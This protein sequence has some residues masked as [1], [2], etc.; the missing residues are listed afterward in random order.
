MYDVSNGKQNIRPSYIIFQH[1]CCCI[2]R[3]RILTT[4]THTHVR[5]VQFFFIIYSQW[6]S[7]HIRLC[8]FGL[9]VVVVMKQRALNIKYIYNYV[10]VCLFMACPSLKIIKNLIFFFLKKTY[11]SMDVKKK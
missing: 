4:W 5:L 2:I 7:Q 11:T 3:F 10:Y 9:S 1:I 6:P 8:V